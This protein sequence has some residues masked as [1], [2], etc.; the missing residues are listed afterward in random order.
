MPQQTF[1]LHH[2]NNVKIKLK[3]QS[4][5]FILRRMFSNLQLRKDIT[6]KFRQRRNLLFKS[7]NKLSNH[8]PLKR[9]SLIP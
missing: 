9:L 8:L 2:S 1:T 7:N 6:L 4:I 5:R 3:L